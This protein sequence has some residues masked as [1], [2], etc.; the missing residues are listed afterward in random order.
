MKQDIAIMTAV[1]RMGLNPTLFDDRNC[2]NAYAVGPL[3]NVVYKVHLRKR[4]G[5]KT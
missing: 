2:W 4:E 5:Y 3:R 1:S